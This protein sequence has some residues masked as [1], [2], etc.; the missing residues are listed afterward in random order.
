MRVLV[1]EPIAKLGIE[2]LKANFDVDVA[3]EMTPEDLLERIAEYDALI[4][5]SATKVTAEVIEKASKLRVVG[6]AGI[7]VDNVDVKAA[8]KRG[9]IVCNA[10]ESNIV[11]AAEHAIALLLA[12][13]RMIPQANSS[14]KSGKW[15][16]GKFKGVELLNKTIGIVGLGK[17]GTLVANRCRG[18]SLKVIAYDPYLTSEKVKELG[19]E[20][21]DSLDELLAKSDFITIHLPKSKETLGMF[22]AEEIAKMKDGVR[23]VNAARGGILDEDA[24]A[25]A[26]RSGKVASAGIDVFANEPCTESPLFELDQV[27]V[28]PHLGAST[29][30]AQDKAG[31]VI[32]EQVSAALKGEFV[33]NAVN[34]PAISQEVVEVLKPYLPLC[35]NL[36][37][38]FG[39]IAEGRL[40]SL[41]VEYEGHVAEQ[42][43][44]LLT[45]AAIKG[46]MEGFGEE[47]VNYV[48]AP[49]VAEEKGLIVREV[50]KPTSRDYTNLITLKGS[51]RRGEM[52]AGGTL[53]GPKNKPRFVKLYRHDIDIE[54]SKY[55]AFFR[56]KDVPGMIGRVGTILGQEEINI[57]TMQVGRKKVAG[58]AVMGVT[59]DMPISDEVLEKIRKIEGFTE[60]KQIEL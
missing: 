13:A 58:E 6:R 18:L 51:D 53:I 1:K 41:D 50:K 3:P 43:T 31:I 24:L 26:V 46:L 14:L 8:T 10:P 39:S 47:G 37:K 38:L 4:V 56:Y 2:S 29:L 44:K 48:N 16:R 9:I 17:I 20:M 7:G 11:S 33:S 32:A 45:I 25:E 34:I 36:G 55:T 27:V 59:L 60:V 42:E 19:F 21:V 52:I 28:T 22:G 49:V 12:Q 35:E 57:A 5:R 15:E 23:I 54:P 30:E 40:E